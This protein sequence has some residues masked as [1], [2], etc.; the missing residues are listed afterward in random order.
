[1]HQEFANAILTFV[2]Y[3]RTQINNMRA[4]TKPWSSYWDWFDDGQL[5]FMN[6]LELFIQEELQEYES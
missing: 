4:W 2:W 1:M 5:E 6:R 3:S